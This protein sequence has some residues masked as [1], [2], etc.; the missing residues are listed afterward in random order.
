MKQFTKE[1]LFWI[2][3]PKE[4]E[5]S[6]DKIVMVTEP[7]TDLWQETH[8]NNSADTAPVLQMQTDQESFIFTVKA[9]F[10]YVDL[11]DQC[12]IAIYL[13]SKNWMK[14]SSENIDDHQKLGSVVTNNGFSDWATRD[15][16]ANINHIWYRLTR[17]KADFIIETS[18][19]GEN[20]KQMRIFHLHKAEGKSEISF[21]LYACSPWD[22]P[23]TATFSKMKVEEI[24]K[25]SH[26]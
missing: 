9:S 11:Y 18:F 24:E 10:N 23:F 14:A 22:G 17:E 4:F 6:D 16:P 7:D 15:I 12:G 1:N 21:G 5:I 3:E 19:D 8:Y 25:S 26:K 13:D 2:R 20:F